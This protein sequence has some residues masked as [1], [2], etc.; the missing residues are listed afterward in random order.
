MLSQKCKYAIRAVLYL[1]KNASEENKLGVKDV[2]G[3]LNLPQ[4]FTAKILQELARKNIVT[5]NKGPGGGFF[6][7]NENKNKTLYHIIEAIDGDDFFV[8]CGLGLHVCSD[9]NPCPLHNDFKKWRESLHK[10]FSKIKILQIQQILDK[11]NIRL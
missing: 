7:T 11:D 9:R 3:T 10:K 5:S 2:A 8:S 1:S 4:A 6:L